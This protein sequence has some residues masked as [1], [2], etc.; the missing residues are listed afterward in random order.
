MFTWDKAKQK[1]YWSVTRE[2]TACQIQEVYS[3]IFFEFLL[4]DLLDNSL[5]FIERLLLIDMIWVW[6]FH[7]Q[8]LY[9]V[10]MS[11]KHDYWLLYRELRKIKH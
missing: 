8:L 7:L 1:T 9:Q 2:G 3:R 11:F 6:I 5:S 4:C 10:I